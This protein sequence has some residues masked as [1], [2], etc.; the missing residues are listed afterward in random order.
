MRFENPVLPGVPQPPARPDGLAGRFWPSD[1]VAEVHVRPT[2]RSPPH[3]GAMMV[4]VF[5][6]SLPETP[7][8]GFRDHH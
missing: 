8:A 6:W 3:D 2:R 7:T 1:L 4:P 5:S